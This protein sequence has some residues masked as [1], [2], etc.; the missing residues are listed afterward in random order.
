M[1]VYELQWGLRLIAIILVFHAD[2]T[3]ACIL[4]L[5]GIGYAGVCYLK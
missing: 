4:F 1:V 3:C 2:T 5:L